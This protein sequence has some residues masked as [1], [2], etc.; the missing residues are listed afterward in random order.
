VD[1]NPGDRANACQGLM[2]AVSYEVTGHKGLI[3]IFKCRKCG[4]ETRNV[5]AHEDAADPD[6]YDRI[7][8]LRRGAP[9][10]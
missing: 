1:V 6:D 5:A 7:L 3:L 8:A 9:P 10:R 2:D 4:G